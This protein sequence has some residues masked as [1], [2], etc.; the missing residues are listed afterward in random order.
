MGTL[1]GAHI[2]WA[3]ARF[4]HH[5]IQI[6]KFNRLTLEVF[7]KV[8]TPIKVGKIEIR[9]SQHDLDQTIDFSEEED[10][11]YLFSKNNPIKIDK[12]FYIKD[13]DSALGPIMLNKITLQIA[14]PQ[15]HPENPKPT[16]NLFFDI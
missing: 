7:S 9:L 8:S 13:D 12:E 11:C 3:R 2:F 14:T 1:S 6:N 5:L 10:G 4:Q 16:H 15:F